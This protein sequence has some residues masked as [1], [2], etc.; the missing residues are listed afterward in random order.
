M[1]VES[2]GRRG[3]EVCGKGTTV[4]VDIGC[5][6]TCGAGSHL[7]LRFRAPCSEGGG[8]FG[9]TMPA[10]GPARTALEK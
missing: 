2:G 4:V 8:T 6:D 10:S 1:T 9:V 5:D 7:A 3:C